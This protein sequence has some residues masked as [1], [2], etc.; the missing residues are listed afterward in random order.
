VESL[1]HGWLQR[2][3]SG[4]ITR[5]QLIGGLAMLATAG[6]TAAAA[7]FQGK[8]IDHVSI[9]SGNP[10]RSADFYKTTFG[11]S[12]VRPD[13]NDGAIRLGEDRVLIAIR[14]GTPQ[15]VVDHFG[16]GVTPF[17][18]DLIVRDLKAHGIAT[19][20]TPGDAGFHVKD[21]DGISVQIMPSDPR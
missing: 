7:G 18:K 16:V 5:R 12:F 19:I 10:Q 4:G 11:L 17:D 13:L 9:V 21:P 2:Y 8:G 14:Q 6:R 1:I 15:G 20:D 3:E